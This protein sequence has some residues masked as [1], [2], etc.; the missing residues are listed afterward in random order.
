MKRRTFLTTTAG[1]P[2]LA[3]CLGNDESSENAPED[4]ETQTDDESSEN[5]PEDSETQTEEYSGQAA[6]LVLSP[7]EIPSGNWSVNQ[8]REG[9]FSPPGMEDS[10]VIEMAEEETDGNE[11][12]IGVMVFDSTDA[13]RNFY[14]DQVAESEIE[15]TEE[16][17]G[18]ESISSSSFGLVYFEVRKFNI[19]LQVISTLHRSTTRQIAEEQLEHIRNADGWR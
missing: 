16:R 2:L 18:D 19:H 14:R 4:S 1:S 10:H 15:S 8:E 6:S 13:T 11:L 12:N 3:G 5:A 7:S 9:N 17:L